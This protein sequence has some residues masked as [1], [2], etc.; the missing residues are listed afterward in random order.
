MNKLVVLVAAALSQCIASSSAASDVSE[1]ARSVLP[2]LR[3]DVEFFANA[4]YDPSISTPEKLIGFSPGAR[5]AK[6]A[7]I[8][9]C[10]KAWNAE[11][12]RIHLVAS[13]SENLARLDP[14][15]KDLA[16]LSDPRKVDASQA[17]NL[18]ETLPPVAWLAYSIHG[19]ESSGS[20]AALAVLYHLAAATDAETKALLD[21]SIVIIDP[22][23]NPDGRDRHLKQIEE[24]RGAMPNVDHQ[25]LLHRGDW[26]GGRTNHYLFDL[27]R[28]WLFGVQP[29]TQGRI[30]AI[31]AW[32][33]VLMVDVHEMGPLDTYLF[34]PPREPINPNI[35]QRIR[36]W[37]ALF[38]RDQAA[39][40]DRM[41]W[42][43]Y[44]GEWVDNWYPGY[45]DAWAQYRGAVGILYEQARIYEDA[46]R[47]PEGSLLT[48][49]E[50]VHHQVVSTMAN[51]ATFRT[52]GRALLREFLHERRRAVDPSGP[53]AKQ[54]FVVL[55]SANAARI[56]R[57]VNLMSLQGVEV[58]QTAQDFVAESA[59]DPLGRTHK[60][61]TIPAG[62]LLIPHRQ[63]LAHWVGALL[64]FDPQMKAEALE[65]ER[66]ELLR[67][68][69][70]ASTIYDI[71]GWSIPLLFGLDA[72]VLKQDLPAGVL[73]YAPKDFARPT[74]LD[75][76]ATALVIDGSDDRSVSA[77][78]R[79][80]ERGVHVRVADKAFALDGQSFA[81]GS[82]VIAHEDNAD[83]PG[84]FAQTAMAVA[85]ELRL[86]I[87]TVRS[88]MGEGDLP[89]LGG[90]HFIR[91][92]RPQVAV[93]TRDR[94]NPNSYG[95]IW[96]LLDRELGIRH[97]HLDKGL[98]QRMDL[99][100][101]NVLVL[102]RGP[103]APN[104]LE[105]LKEWVEAG[106]TLIA[107]GQAAEDLVKKEGGLS[108]A[109]NLPDVL[110]KLDE[111]EMAL[112]REWLAEQGDIPDAQQMW[113]HVLE[114]DLNYPWEFEEKSARPKKEALEKRDKWQAMFMPQGAI[115]A[116]RVDQKHWLTFGC[117]NY[118]P[119]L[120]GT[121]WG[122]PVLMAAGSVQAPVRLG[123]FTPKDAV[124]KKKNDIARVGWAAVPAGQE[125]RLRMS[126]LLWPEAAHRL[127]NAAYATQEK[128]GKGQIILFA[129]DPAF[130]GAALG[131]ARLFA[132][133]LVYGPGLGASHP[134]EP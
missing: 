63:P 20:D 134:I 112:I 25:S 8:E 36:G 54:C 53:F 77:A 116:S 94:T 83:A 40:F 107:V 76:E 46:V 70:S 16:K 55:P 1:T 2:G 95:S 64:E 106:G 27:N 122:I 90:R 5:A 88:G 12:E 100:P 58:Y 109:R 71:T 132:N 82:V 91:V 17:D 4:T 57:F 47:R 69:Q 19:N 10:L 81:R 129:D 43:Y 79:L 128:L 41:Q 62:A 113:A 39:A 101:Y 21:S 126:G 11:S 87:A 56:E 96:F 29:E 30:R 72:L 74:A 89:D 49:R 105:P 13:S 44:T 61:A 6:H 65:K 80:A 42:H 24:V 123:V 59:V 133:A 120:V 60:K 85:A 31:S 37:S 131:S 121:G 125:M 118:L 48:Y 115:L 18:A 92:E 52:K 97:T 99:R 93:L 26:P 28:D 75:K 32:H 84:D 9:R 34:S 68:G 114:A 127:A 117:E 22:M 67:H 73:R 130:R 7:E 3:Y 23:M 45:S 51:L 15:Q 98:L 119:V 111:Y 110:D 33:P 104:V 103:I 102:P 124:D 66:G 108:K 38:A 78:A 50:A 86:D 14:I 35:P